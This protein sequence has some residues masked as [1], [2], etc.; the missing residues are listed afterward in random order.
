[1]RIRYAFALVLFVALVATAIPADAAPCESLSTLKLPDTTITMAQSV[2]AGAYT[3]AA[4]GGRG[5]ARGG[6]AA[7]PYADLPAFCR[8]ALTIK[9]TGDSDIKVEV[10]MPMSGWNGKFQGVGNGGWSGS[11]AVADLATGLRRGYATASTDTGHEGGSASFALG[12]TEKL[13]DFGHRAVHEMTVKGKAI[14]T[15][16]YDNTAPRYAYFV[17]CSAGGKQGIKAAQMYPEDYDGIVAGSPGV[18]WSGRALQSIWVGQAVAR[19][20][21]PSAKFPAINAAA[22]AACDE[23]DGVKDGVIENPRQCKF[24]P[25][26]LICK[27]ED[28]NTCL[29][30]PQIETAK[31]IYANVSNSRTRQSHVAGLS[32]GSEAGWGTMA[33]A[34]PFGPG[35]D[36]FRYVVF[37]DPTWDFKTLN[38]DSDLDKTLKASASM[39]ALDPNL[40]PFFDRGGKILSYHGWNDPQISPGSTVD[41]Y[42]S[43]LDKMGGAAKV[44]ENFR[45]FM[46]PGMNHCQ[47]GV[48]TD[49]FDKLAVLENWV[50]K[51]QT[52]ASITASRVANG[53]TV[54]T[55]P[56]CPYPQVASYKGSGSTDD[57][58]NVVCK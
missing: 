14:T 43:V 30:A 5:G 32:P 52:P 10:W 28:N 48:G 17:G 49:Q 35:M 29:T 57:A 50:E 46:V 45:L 9:P 16:F 12:H 25:A 11:I 53:Q 19:T 2:A 42:Q 37:G 33:G 55:R 34:Q 38:W 39:D 54:R 23:L 6:A 20:P 8:V 1:M 41:Y 18:N 58:A 15:A 21:I 24:D 47:G 13:I 56:L 22:V 7:N 44:Q 36:L 3:P 26:A 4:G 27:A 51:K 40:K 31:Q